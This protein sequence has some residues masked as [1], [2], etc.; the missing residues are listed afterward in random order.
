MINILAEFKLTRVGFDKSIKINDVFDHQ[1]DS[2]IIRAISS[3]RVKNRRV[4]GFGGKY[5][6]QRDVI[7]VDVVAQK[8]GTI[9]V[10]NLSA[11]NSSMTWT[12][13]TAKVNTYDGD[14]FINI[15]E[16]VICEDGRTYIVTQINEI[17]YKFVDIKI[18]FEALSVTE[19]PERE[20]IKLST[21]QKITELG[22]QVI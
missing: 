13:N 6:I 19:L 21:K 18:D 2:W 16:S 5:G 15:G 7:V 17:G 12:I 1:N 11:K 22:W 9:N 8:V 14:N 10:M 4:K 20:T 3:S